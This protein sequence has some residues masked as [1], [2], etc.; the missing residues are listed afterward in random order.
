[1]I[2]LY[3]RNIKEIIV[4]ILYFLVIALIVKLFINHIN[5]SNKNAIIEN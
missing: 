2:R 5:N 4:Y 3:K 1:M